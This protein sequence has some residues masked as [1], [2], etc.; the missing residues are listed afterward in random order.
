MLA[1]LFKVA[2]LLVWMLG[3]SEAVE[4]IQFDVLS[5]DSRDDFLVGSLGLRTGAIN[6]ALNGSRMNAFD[7]SDSLRTKPF[8]SLLNG[9]LD[10]L[11]W[12]FEVIKGRA[13]A[14]TECPFVLL[15]SDD[16]YGLAT[17]EPVAAVIS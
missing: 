15:T 11:L 17:L 1:D 3:A 6:P 4:F 12:G 9:A 16:G 10:F 8:E 2:F 13:V 14:V 7:A 5:R